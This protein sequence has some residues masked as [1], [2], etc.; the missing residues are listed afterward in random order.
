MLQMQETHLVVF[1]VPVHVKQSVGQIGGVQDIIGEGEEAW[2]AVVHHINEHSIIG[3]TVEY[4]AGTNAPHTLRITA[5]NLQE[6]LWSDVLSSVVFGHA[7]VH[8]GAAGSV[9]HHARSWISGRTKGHYYYVVR[10]NFR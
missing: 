8:V 1:A 7:F 5:Q 9:D 6:I 10:N 4:P 2:S 3:A